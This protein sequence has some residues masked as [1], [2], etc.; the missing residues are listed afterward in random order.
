MDASKTSE[1][2][3]PVCLELRKLALSANLTMLAFLL[4]MAALEATQKPIE[5]S[6]EST[7][8]AA[9]TMDPGTQTKRHRKA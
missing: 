3:G 1:Y 4:G 6:D 5:T 7:K 9:S 8:Q 2:I